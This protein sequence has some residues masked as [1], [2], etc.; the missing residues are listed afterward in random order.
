MNLEQRIGGNSNLS[1]RGRQYAE[2]L[3]EFIRNEKLAD[4]VAWTSQYKRTIQTASKIDAPKE[5]WKALNE[6]YAVSD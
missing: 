6:I 1:A 3:A 4:L 5:Q 2:K